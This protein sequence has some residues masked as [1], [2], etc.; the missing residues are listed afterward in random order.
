VRVK[1]ATGETTTNVTSVASE[2]K[3]GTATSATPEGTNT[4]VSDGTI[5]T[6]G[7]AKTVT[8]TTTGPRPNPTTGKMQVAKVKVTKKEDFLASAATITGDET[9][10]KNGTVTLTATVDPTFA[11]SVVWTV[12]AGTGSAAFV[13]GETTAATVTAVVDHETGQATATLKGL[14]AGTVTV[15]VKAA[16]DAATTLNETAKTVTVLN[17]PATLTTAPT[18]TSAAS[19]ASYVLYGSSTALV[20]T[21][22]A[23]GGTMMYA[24]TTDNT[25][26]AKSAFSSTVPTA[27]GREAG[28]YYVWYY[29]Q[30]DDSHIDTDISSTSILVPVV[31][32][33]EFNSPFSTWVESTKSITDSNFKIEAWKNSSML[34]VSSSDENNRMSI[35]SLNSQKIWKI[36]LD[37]NNARI[38][39]T[40]TFTPNSPNCSY[41]YNNVNGNRYSIIT[42]NS[43]DFIGTSCTMTLDQNNGH[44]GFNK[45]TI[46]YY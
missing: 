20:T 27:S 9:V 31:K 41:Y 26:P 34:W 17:V 39:V 12:T 32:S 23:S 30:G 42:R 45:V 43:T 33:V 8:V 16:G 11:N 36:R 2:D 46:Y 35:S 21:G 24:V 22:A 13:S 28:K 38:S 1:T 18:A 6:A 44:G 15:N 19:E 14:E 37:F 40:P 25:Q 5:I 10:N 7:R 3:D 4:T 29:V